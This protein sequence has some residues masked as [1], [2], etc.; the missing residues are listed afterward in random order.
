VKP[1]RVLAWILFTVWAAWAFALRGALAD[2]GARPWVPDFGLV[3]VL[4][5]LAHLEA[6]DVPL[7]VLL[8]A[9]ARSSVS[10]EPALVLLAGT[11]AVLALAL[12]LR[13][14]IELSNPWWRAASAAVL[15]LGFDEWLIVVEHVRGL[16]GPSASALPAPGVFRPFVPAIFSGLFALFAGGLLAYLPGLSPLRSR[17]W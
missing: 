10:V 16:Q 9:L 11:G 13:S 14:V 4:G 15:V 3:L 12:T 6:R 2:G 5:L 1:S 17:R 8:A 7:C